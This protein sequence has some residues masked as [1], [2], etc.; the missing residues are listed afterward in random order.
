MKFA[1]FATR[2]LRPVVFALAFTAACLGSSAKESALNSLAAM[3]QMPEDIVP[4][5]DSPA[6]GHSGAPEKPTENENMKLTP[7]A[8]AALGFAPDAAPTIEEICAA[9]TKL[10][11]TEESQETPAQEASETEAGNS[12]PNIISLKAERDKFLG[13]A[14]NT[15]ITQAINTGRI[16]EADKPAWVTALN[17]SFESESAK[18][19]KLMPVFNT[20][21]KLPPGTSDRKTL[22]VTDAS[23]AAA[24]I[25]D[26]VRDLAGEKNIDITNQAG[27]DRAFA[28]TREAKPDLFTKA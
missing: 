11:L 9:I 16:T 4:A 24:R 3:G 8:L 5:K 15:A 7:E 23:N 10:A 17:T 6:A 25:T 1:P 13:I 14:V 22:N 2:Y 12:N 20:S 27:W 19:E 26:A 28:L 21:S 18:L